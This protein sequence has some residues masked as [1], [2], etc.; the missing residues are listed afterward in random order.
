M[1]VPPPRDPHKPGEWGRSSDAAWN[2]LPP[3]AALLGPLLIGGLYVASGVFGLVRTLVVA[4]VAFAVVFL[5]SFGVH[6]RRG[7]SAAGAID[8]LD[9]H[10]E[11]V[12]KDPRLQLVS[13]VQHRD[14]ARVV[15]ALADPVLRSEAA[16]HLGAMRAHKAVPALLRALHTEDADHRVGVIT[17]LGEIG[18][19]EAIGVLVR[20]RNDAERAVRLAAINALATIGVS[21]AIEELARIVVEPEPPVLRRWA[22]QRLVQLRATGALPIL[23]NRRHS[24]S[25]ARQ[26]LLLWRTTRALRKVA[27]ERPP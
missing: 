3:A 21:S 26:R 11:I 7:L 16:A 4:G 10:P 22:A 1:V 24:R 20:L 23:E 25:G 14:V 9:R 5:I 2:K 8:Y 17:A 12:A 27:R 15:S 6:V 19:R 13:A 18:D